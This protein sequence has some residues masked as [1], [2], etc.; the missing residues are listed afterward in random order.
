MKQKFIVKTALYAFFT[1]FIIWSVYVNTLK[2]DPQ[3]LI[4]LVLLVLILEA[5]LQNKKL[6]KR[7]ELKYENQEEL[8]NTF[9]SNCPDLIAYKNEKLK[10]ITC[11]KAM[12]T[13]FKLKTPR[14]IKNY[15]V[16]E[17]L[18]PKPASIIMEHDKKVLQTGKS[19]KYV[20]KL[21]HPL[22]GEKIYDVISAPTIHR[23]EVMGLVTVAR[24]ITIRE[25]LRTKFMEKQR[26]IN[27]MIENLPMMAFLTDNEGRYIRGNNK[28]LKILNVKHNEILGINVAKEYTK[29]NLETIAYETK[30]VLNEKRSLVTE[31]I[32]NISDN[33]PTW[34]KEYR[35]PIFDEKRNVIGITVFL[36]DIQNEKEASQQKERFIATL[37]H[38]LKTPTIAQIRSLEML[39]KGMF[40]EL[41]DEQTEMLKMTMESCQNMYDMVSTVLY[42]YKFEN[43][44][45]KL[46]YTDVCLTELAAECC[47]DLAKQSNEKGIEILIKPK[48][49]NDTLKADRSF[50]KRAVSNILENSISYAFERTKVEIIIKETKDSL[51]L[52]IKTES[53]FIKKDAIKTMFDKY[54]GQTS[55]NKI[56]FCLKLH[57][58]KQIVEAHFGKIIAKSKET[59]M[60]TFGF[61]L[62]KSAVEAKLKEKVML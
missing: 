54:L 48:T 19:I 41:N 44:E 35:V 13:L 57:L 6:L 39:I 21:E 47:N 26:Q 55:Y 4:M 60:N 28:F 2:L 29:T 33:P 20:L 49:K 43:N 5:Y 15:S 61:S 12:C 34:Y 18:P 53:P 7:L 16:M 37:S 3:A 45:I 11:N 30:V 59:N 14:Q 9:S 58:S 10:Y 25:R 24:D 22:L 50:I 52:K 17:L 31:H 40:G 62:P 46:N 32:Y 8:I 1:G 23:G 42:S 36:M 27:E 38:D 56:G 51:K